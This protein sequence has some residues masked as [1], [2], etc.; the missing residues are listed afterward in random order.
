MKTRGGAKPGERRGGRKKGT[1]NKAT[2]ERERAAALE[3]EHQALLKQAEA[4]AGTAKQ[5]LLVAMAQGRKLMKEIAFDF[6]HLFAGMAA[7]YQPTP[8]GAAQPNPNEN[9]PKFNEYARLAV[10]TAIAAA[11]FESP[12][13]AAVML[14]SGMVTQIEMI[15]GLPD[16][17]DGGFDAS[18]DA[19][20]IDGTAAAAEPSAGGSGHSA[21]GA[22]QGAGGAADIP[23]GASPAVPA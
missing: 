13:L 12:K 16:K 15:G 9:E 14:Q 1:P 23:S 17:E 18:T 11:P 2:I 4:E 20:T 22:D 21:A 5:D 3:L 19:N 7:F 10:Q 6:A 8:P